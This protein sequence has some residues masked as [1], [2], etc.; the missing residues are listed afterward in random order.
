MPKFKRYGDEVIDVDRVVRVRLGGTGA[1]ASV[2]LDG[3]PSQV[4]VTGAEDVKRLLADLKI[5]DPNAPKGRKTYA[6]DKGPSE[7]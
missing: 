5:A 7:A 3:E 2:R 4:E 1:K 6:L